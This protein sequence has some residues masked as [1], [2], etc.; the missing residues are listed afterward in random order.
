MSTPRSR[1]P[2]SDGLANRER[3]LA[4]AG[5]LIL[6]RGASVPLLAVAQAA[7]LGIG[8][9]YRHFEDRA[10][11]LTALYEPISSH[12]RAGVLAA[13]ADADAP[14]F[15]RIVAIIDATVATYLRYPW[16]RHVV[17]QARLL[18]PERGAEVFGAESRALVEAA[19]RD[20]SL[21]PD[22]EVSDLLVIPLAIEA[23]TALPPPLHATAIPRLRAI[24]LSGLQ[25]PARPP[26]PLPGMPA[27]P[28]TV[29]LRP[30]GRT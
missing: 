26:Q 29:R 13:F 1:R 19:K 18:V 12:W 27:Q 21:R 2:R 15:E 14:P 11:L 16:F 8:T 5:P 6:E 22:V 25:G 24:L 4:A 7:G 3:I 23:A 9:L 20:G 28:D 17:P 10:A 30:D